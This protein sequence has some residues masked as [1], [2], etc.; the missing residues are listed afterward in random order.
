MARAQFFFLAAEGLVIVLSALVPQVQIVCTCAMI[1]DLLVP[2]LEHLL[3]SVISYLR[4]K[5]LLRIDFRDL[6]VVCFERCQLLEFSAF[7][8]FRYCSIRLGL[9]RM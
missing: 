6:H 2:V 1:L 7:H 5:S 3:S 4:R 9:L 8:Y